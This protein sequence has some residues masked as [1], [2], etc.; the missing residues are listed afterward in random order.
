MNNE[1]M[2]LPLESESFNEDLESLLSLSN[3]NLELIFEELK[4][5]GIS[6]SEI[7]IANSLEMDVSDLRSIM[8]L[9]LYLIPKIKD[10]KEKIKNEMVSL[11][12]DKD[13]ISFLIDKI[14]S[15]DE[16]TYNICKILFVIGR[17]LASKKH[18]REI[19]SEL[20]FV[21]L[22]KDNNNQTLLLP[23]I[24]LKIKTHQEDEESSDDNFVITI[25]AKKLKE[26]IT[27]LQTLLKESQA[28]M[29][30]LKDIL[31]N[32]VIMTLGDD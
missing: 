17:Y 30:E 14:F 19:R 32:R 22:Y 5:Q 15:L 25:D 6:I 9:L 11:N 7:H 23:I 26:L 2:I 18:I 24:N 20:N 1:D 31:G 13:K 27:N 8:N 16:N 29:K 4:N 21:P 10:N 3:Q 28:E 12:L